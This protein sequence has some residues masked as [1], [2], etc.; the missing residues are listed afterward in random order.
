[1]FFFIFFVCR[2]VDSFEKIEMLFTLGQKSYKDKAKS[3]LCIFLNIEKVFLL[4]SIIFSLFCFHRRHIIVYHMERTKKKKYNYDKVMR[5]MEMKISES[6]CVLF[7]Q[8]RSNE[9]WLKQKTK[10]FESKFNRIGDSEFV[11]TRNL[12]ERFPSGQFTEAYSI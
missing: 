6:V 5:D 7:R 11:I 8:I 1:M 4:I 3:L 10:G 12:K 2:S 9:K